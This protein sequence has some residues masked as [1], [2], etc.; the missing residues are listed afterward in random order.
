VPALSTELVVDGGEATLEASV[1]TS[2]RAGDV[3]V[4]DEQWWPER[5]RVGAPGGGR[6]R[7]WCERDESGTLTVAEIEQGRDAAPK[8]G[9]RMIER[10]ETHPTADETAAGSREDGL[11]A[12]GDAPVALSLEIARFELSLED[13][14]ALQPGEVVATGVVIGE[15]VRLRAGTKVVATGELVEVEGEVGVR[16]TRLGG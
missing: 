3:I 1:V 13:V 6:T 16:L 14:A 11:E 8:E 5:A 9:R 12:I 2:L 4:P 7:W 10:T 15:E